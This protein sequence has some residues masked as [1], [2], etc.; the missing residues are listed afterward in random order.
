MGG[1]GVIVVTNQRI[2]DNAL[3][4]DFTLFF[5]ESSIFLVIKGQAI[6]ALYFSPNLH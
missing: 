2:G 6:Q 4:L 1:S 3:V 5:Q